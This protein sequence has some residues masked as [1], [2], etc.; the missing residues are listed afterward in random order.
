M[1]SKDIYKDTR[2]EYTKGQLDEVSISAS[3]F[4]QFSQWLNDAATSGHIEP[5]ACALGTAGTDGS[6]SVRMV[7]LKSFNESGFVF[8]TN[9]TS[10]KGRHLA[11]NPK[12]A[13]LFHWPILE[14]QVRIEGRCEKIS[15]EESDQYFYSR[16]RGAQLG[17][18]VSLQSQQAQSRQTI[19]DS[20]KK[21]E[22]Q[23]GEGRVPRPDTWGGYRLIP[24]EFEF[25][26]GRESRLHDRIRY[27]RAQ[28]AWERSR[29][30]P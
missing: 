10:K 30:W 26:Q 22:Q 18:A 13:L 1:S 15:A 9:Y 6:P 2:K 25:W 20:Y 19:E 14:R 12:A 4:E 7:L 11:T 27:I 28:S 21:L 8:F 3:P 16:P 17:A 24:N 23:V 5:T 29:L